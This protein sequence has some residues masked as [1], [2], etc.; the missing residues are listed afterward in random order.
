[1]YFS[2]KE[3]KNRHWKL[4]TVSSVRTGSHIGLGDKAKQLF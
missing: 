4:G 3:R 1:M 2:A